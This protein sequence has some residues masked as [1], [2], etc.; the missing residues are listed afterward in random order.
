MQLL[1]WGA[2]AA[3]FA[4][5]LG[6]ALRARQRNQS[7]S[8]YAIGTRTIPP[9]VIGMSLAAQL[10]SV[11]T[12]VVNPGLVY[13]Y[14]VAAVW[15]YGVAAGLGI[16]IGLTVLSRRFRRQGD[17][18]QAMTVPQWIE[19]RYGSRPL[20]ALFALLSLGLLTF[21]TLII[22]GLSYA[23][24]LPLGLPPHVI[25]IAIVILAVT[26]VTMG[27]ATGHAWTNAVQASV[28]VI[29]AVVLIGAGL[30]LLSA[31]PDVSAA[32]SSVSPH[33]LG[34]INPDS[35]YFRS[36]FE[37]LLCNFVVGLAIVCQPHIISKS[38]Y[39]REDRDVRV[40]LTTA[41][42]IGLLF[43]AVLV[44]GV[45]ARLELT[46]VARIDRAI[47]TWI[48][49][50]FSGPVEV[51]IMIGLL[52]A[53]L[54][55]LEGILLALSSILSIDVYPR[56]VRSGT[57][58]GALAM[59]RLGLIA[60]GIVVAALALWQIEHPTGGSVAIFAQYGVYLLFS[61][62][63]VPLACGMFVPKA[64]RGLV[65]AA[66]L[67]CLAAYFGAAFFEFTRYHNN[68]GFLAFTGITSAWLVVAAGLVSGI[69]RLEPP[70]R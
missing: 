22:V 55:T 61:A 32:L 59:G 56:L 50:S 30:P 13:A 10:T 20:G 45:W 62:S 44:T 48:A 3:Y 60:V 17:R 29:V 70:S 21:A 43:T 15:G 54:S 64:G 2:I 68:P 36:V 26:A 33:F 7:V 16:F 31:T 8:A 37:V 66:V 11:A 12:F 27:G 5:T 1:A 58:R 51:L 34:M 6:V 19:K 28:M 47:P 49:A 57:D 35:P 9:V 24:S 53:G 14:G 46:E 18:V 4:L 42:T 65:T 67:T 40:Y 25:A 63:F 23:L 69:G 39:L 52:S 41:I 38:L